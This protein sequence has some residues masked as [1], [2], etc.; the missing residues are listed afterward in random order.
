[1][2]MS[3]I[4][5]ISGISWHKPRLTTNLCTHSPKSTAPRSPHAA[6][7]DSNAT[8]SAS[9]PSTCILRNTSTAF[10]GR[11]ICAYPP[12]TVV[13][14]TTFRSGIASNS[15]RAWAWSPAFT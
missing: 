5:F 1:M 4:E 6:R 10:S 8:P 11:F 9:M 14:D 13:H 3:M 7:T 15:S 12:I 2:Y